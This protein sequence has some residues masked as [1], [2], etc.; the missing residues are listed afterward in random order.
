MKSVLFVA[1]SLLLASSA[2]AQNAGSATDRRPSAPTESTS[3]GTE[4]ADDQIICRRIQADTG[5][6]L[7]G[8]RRVCMTRREWRDYERQN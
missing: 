7:K 3:G 1:S 5:T 8:N 2:L 6:R 4:S